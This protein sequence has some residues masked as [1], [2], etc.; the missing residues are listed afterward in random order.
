MNSGGLISTDL[1]RQGTPWAGEYW[2]NLQQDFAPIP[3]SLRH[4]F[5]DLVSSVAAFTLE[6]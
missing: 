1:D 5:R 3:S 4:R 2:A 6:E